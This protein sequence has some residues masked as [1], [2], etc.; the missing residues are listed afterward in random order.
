MLIPVER[1]VREYGVEAAPVL[2]VG[3]H[4]GEEAAQYAR[5]GFKPVWWIEANEDVLPQLRRN[6]WAYEDQHVVSALVADRVRDVQFHLASNGQSSSYMELGTHAV[7]HPDVTYV[8]E[9]P[10]TTTTVDALLKQG[11]ISRAGY[12]SMDVQGCELDVL[13]GA[14][15]FLGTVQTVYAEVNA[16]EVYVGCP[17]FN[18]VSGWLEERGFRMVGSQMTK[19]GWGDAVYR[20]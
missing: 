10:L 9:R 11:A 2:H 3:A 4:V 19:H 5:W 12:L 7:E 14:E 17:L 1:L 6:L 8:D 16:E 13:R 18:E 20:R 15:D